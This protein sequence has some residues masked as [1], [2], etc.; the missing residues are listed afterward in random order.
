MAQIIPPEVGDRHVHGNATVTAEY[1]LG[2]IA[3]TQASGSGLAPLHSNPGAIK[4]QSMSGPDQDTESSYANLVRE[5]T[6]LPLVGMTLATGD[7]SWSARHWDQGV[8]KRV[9]YTH[10]INVRVVADRRSTS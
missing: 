10:A 3:T 9:D 6:G 7:R 5:S 4:W 1:F 2:G 8:G